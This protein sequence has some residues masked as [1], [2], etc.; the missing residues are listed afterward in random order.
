M[1]EIDIPYE[2]D[3]YIA[4]AAKALDIPYSSVTRS[5]RDKTKKM[6]SPW[7]VGFGADM[8]DYQLINLAKLALVEHNL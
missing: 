3:L 5:Q 8:H 7:L 1:T 2:T 4:I 6:I